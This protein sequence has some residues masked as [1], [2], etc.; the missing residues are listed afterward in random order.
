MSNEDF[1]KQV[2]KRFECLIDEATST[3][4]VCQSIWKSEK[5]QSLLQKAIKYLNSGNMASLEEE[6]APEFYEIIV[7]LALRKLGY[8]VIH[9]EHMKRN[10]NDGE[11]TPDFLVRDNSGNEFFVEVTYAVAINSLDRNAQQLMNILQQV[12]SNMGSGLVFSVSVSYKADGSNTEL[13]EEDKKIFRRMQ[14][15]IQDIVTNPASKEEFIRFAGRLFEEVRSRDMVDKI[16]ELSGNEDGLRFTVRLFA[17]HPPNRFKSMVMLSYVGPPY[18]YLKNAIEAKVKKKKKKKYHELDKPVVLFIGVP[19]DIW[20]D[21]L[22]EILADRV[23]RRTQDDFAGYVIHYFSP[24]HFLLNT[25]ISGSFVSIPNPYYE[26]IHPQVLFDFPICLLT[27]NGFKVTKN[28]CKQD[29]VN[30]HLKEVGQ[31]AHD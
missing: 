5:D 8:E 16:W 1:L 24:I 11:K 13:S 15:L 29:M 17:T 12:I 9:Y 3:C 27:H 2:S 21:K 26:G 25:D 7:G 14:T 28:Y 19:G 10:E 23:H 22:H 20:H 6:I 30:E 4:K 18:N 31:D